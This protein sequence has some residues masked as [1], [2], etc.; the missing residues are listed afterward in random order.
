MHK[1]A[2]GWQNRIGPPTI[3]ATGAVKKTS[4]D[5]GKPFRMLRRQLE[6]RGATNKRNELPPLHYSIASSELRRG[7]YSISSQCSSHESQENPGSKRGAWPSSAQGL[8]R[9]ETPE[10]LESV[11]RS[12]S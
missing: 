3:S 1:R 7:N 8:G 2:R 5:H 12:S 11:E 4:R 10:R 6:R 9:V